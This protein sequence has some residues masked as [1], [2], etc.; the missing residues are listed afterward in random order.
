MD[1]AIAFAIFGTLL[2]IRLVA[3]IKVYC[4][5]DLSMGEKFAGLLWMSSRIVLFPIV[6]VLSAVFSLVFLLLAR[7]PWVRARGWLEPILFALA[8][9]GSAA[10]PVALILHDIATE[11]T[12]PGC[13]LPWWPSWLPS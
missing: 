4:V 12:P 8:I 1:I 6:S 7:L 13:V 3:H 2:D 9:A 11:G 10:G 5:G